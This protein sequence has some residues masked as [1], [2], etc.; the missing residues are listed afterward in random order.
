MYR[1]FVAIDMP[2][3]IRARLAGLAYGLP[4][5]RWVPEEQY[6]L[7]L[8]FIGEVDGALF[9]DIAATLETVTAPPCTLTIKGVGCFGARKGPRVLWAGVEADDTLF[10]L[11]RRIEGAL[12]QVG[13]AP[14]R[15]RFSPHVTLARFRTPPP[16][17]RLG[18]FLAGNNLFSAGPMT[19]DTFRLYSSH[20]SSKGAIHQVEA[21]YGLP[22]S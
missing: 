14:E 2:A 13:V 3:A 19:V 22:S 18:R 10:L 9:R 20:L 6:H 11:Q 15:R 16:R 17:E 1:L 4:G 8:R 5:A 7:T 12:V 21:E